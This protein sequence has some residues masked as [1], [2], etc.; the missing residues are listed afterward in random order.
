MEGFPGGIVVKNPPA[1]SRDM[2]SIPG[3]GRSPGIGNG[4]PL[5]YSCQENSMDSSLVG[6]SPWHC[7]ELDM[8]EHA[9]MEYVSRRS[10]TG[11]FKKYRSPLVALE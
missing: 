6:Y 5:Q 9:H 11:L 4:N 7:K 3:S 2:G 8:T 10:K 1:N